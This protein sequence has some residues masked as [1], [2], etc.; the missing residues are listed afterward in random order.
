MLSCL[1][2]SGH[3]VY[4]QTVSSHSQKFVK[5]DVLKNFVKLTGKYLCRSLS[6][7]THRPAAF[8]KTGLRH[9]CFIVNFVNFFENNIFTEQLRTAASV[10]MECICNINKPHFIQPVW[11]FPKEKFRGSRSQ[12]FFKIGVLKNVTNFTIRPCWSFSLF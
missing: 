5:I 6:L 11:L 4:F 10:F 1:F 3:V 12:M 7:I 2:S 8:F 9:S